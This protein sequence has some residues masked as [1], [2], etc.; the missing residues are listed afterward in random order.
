MYEICNLLAARYPKAKKARTVSKPAIRIGAN[1]TVHGKAAVVTRK[2]TRY[3][4]AY[5]VAI[6][7]VEH[8]FSFS[9]DMIV[10]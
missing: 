6:N 9:R 7:G 3:A 2:D 8:K 5:F 10:V 4:S 1:V